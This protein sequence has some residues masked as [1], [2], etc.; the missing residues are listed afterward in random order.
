MTDDGQPDIGIDIGTHRLAYGWPYWTMAASVDLSRHKPKGQSR[1]TELRT[2]QAWLVRYIPTGA[3]L[4]I[5]QPFAGQGNVATAQSMSETVSA[6]LTAQDWAVPPVVVHQSTWK[7]ATVGDPHANKAATHA[8]LSE[9]YPHL[10]VVCDTEDEVDAM[11]IGLYGQMRSNGQVN[12]P[13]PHR[14]RRR[15]RT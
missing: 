4:W 7:V 12:A 11:V 8:W 5:D 13:A 15:A 1:D 9:H 14:P 2:L 6:V 10:A 3:Q